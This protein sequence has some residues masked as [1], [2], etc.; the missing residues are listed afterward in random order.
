MLKEEALAAAKT[1]IATRM[2][3]PGC[4]VGGKEFLG[5]RQMR[6]N[7]KGTMRVRVRPF[8]FSREATA[9]S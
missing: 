5:N 8:S 7:C 2:A 1:K 6:T 9:L 3:G 4:A